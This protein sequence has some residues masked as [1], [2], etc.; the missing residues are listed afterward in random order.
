[1]DRITKRIYLSLII[2]SLSFSAQAQNFIQHKLGQW[3]QIQGHSTF[4]PYKSGIHKP[5]GV[6]GSDIILTDGSY[7]SHDEGFMTGKLFENCWI[8]LGP[9]T[10]IVFNFDAD[11]KILYLKVFTGS[12]KILFNK[13]WTAEKVEKLILETGDKQIEVESAKIVFIKRPFF[14]ENSL[15]VEK[16]LAGVIHENRLQASFVYQ[17]EKMSFNDKTKLTSEISKMSPK[18]QKEISSNQYLKY[19]HQ[20]L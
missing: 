12:A 15:Y 18:E 13:D 19:L 1:M 20:D 6:K 5:N 17:N 4:L 3:T 7:L 16:G 9:K 14:H 8:R 2:G 11:T 10:K